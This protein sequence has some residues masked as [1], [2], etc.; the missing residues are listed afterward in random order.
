M[1]AG[2]IELFT[3][4]QGKDKRQLLNTIR[5]DAKHREEVVLTAID[6]AITEGCDLILFPG[7]TLFGSAIPASVRE[8]SRG[9]T[10][11]LELVSSATEKKGESSKDK[12]GSG[13]QTYV[14]RDVED[15]I[16]PVDQIIIWASDMQDTAKTTSL[17]QALV[18]DKARRWR[19]EKANREALLLVC[20]E[21]N[22]VGGGGRSGAGAR[23]LPSLRDPEARLRGGRLVLN[24]AHTPMRPQAIRDKRAWL[25]GQQGVLLTTANIYKSTA[26]GSAWTGAAAWKNGRPAPLK[27]VPDTWAQGFQLHTLDV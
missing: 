24:P 4:L 22:L 23:N 26:S 19:E 6:H 3:D 20:G 12:K 14:L 16:A 7:W 17:G 5:R 10:L 21:V 9:R 27:L 25:S 2:L 8:R 15:L 1:K 13:R 11:V 18:S